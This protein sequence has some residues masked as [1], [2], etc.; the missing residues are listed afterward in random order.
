LENP[1]E[2]G[3]GHGVVGENEFI[4]WVKSKVGKVG[5]AKREQP[6]LRELG[7]LLEPEELVR[8]YVQIV[9][10]RKEEI[11]RKGTQLA[12]RGMLMEL[13]YRFCNLPQP[14]IGRLL[15]GIDYSA[16]SQSRRR[17]RAGLAKDATLKS[18]FDKI[19]ASLL[20]MSRI[21]I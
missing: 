16:V 3:K 18:K 9:G 5:A 19:M 1:L 2:L 14:E 7:R 17:L 12:E 15:G 20:E 11:C 21:K 13:L 6:A 4:K 8:H 10:K